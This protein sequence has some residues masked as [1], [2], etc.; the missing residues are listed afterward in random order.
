MRF[1]RDTSDR[2]CT[3][4]PHGLHEQRKMHVRVL[5][6]AAIATPHSFL[7][8]PLVLKAR[9]IIIT[10]RRNGVVYLAAL[11][12]SRHCTTQ[13]VPFPTGCLSAAWEKR[14]HSLVYKTA[15][16]VRSPVCAG[17]LKSRS[18]QWKAISG[19]VFLFLRVF[20]LLSLYIFIYVWSK[21]TNRNNSNFVNFNFYIKTDFAYHL[22]QLVCLFW[23]STGWGVCVG[24][25][26]SR[27]C[28]KF[29]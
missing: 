23:G 22:L 21:Q 19:R 4:C 14:D 5:K 15:N 20:F 7:I 29:N 10:A 27:I 24:V 9:G 16:R 6:M 17:G 11:V 8:R 3:A 1:V 12:P 28:L 25:F 2:V 26:S 18:E 13:M